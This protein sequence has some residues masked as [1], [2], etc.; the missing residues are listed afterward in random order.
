M[1]SRVIKLCS[2]KAWPNETQVDASRKLA[3]TCVSVWPGLA[4]TCVDLP[5]LASTWDEI[6]FAR[7]STQSFHRLATQRKSCCLLQV[8]NCS[9]R[10]SIE[11]AYLITCVHLL[12]SLRVHLASQGNASLNASS[13]FDYLRLIALPFGQLFY[14][15]FAEVVRVTISLKI[16]QGQKLSFFTFFKLF[17]CEI[18]HQ[19]LHGLFCTSTDVNLTLPLNPG[20]QWILQA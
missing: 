17:A 5:W 4:C 14:S 16:C 13:I 3:S 2:V 15:G 1:L 12:V 9:A 6:K 8:L 10:S 18:Q 19:V 11:M 20:F 7:K